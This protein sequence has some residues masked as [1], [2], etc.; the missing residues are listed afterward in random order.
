VSAAT[1]PPAGKLL[2]LEQ[3]Q[4]AYGGIR[5][6]KGIDLTVEPNETVCLIGANGAGKTTT[7]KA[8]TGLVRAAAGKI[9]AVDMVPCVARFRPLW[10]QLGVNK[11][12]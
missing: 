7:L 11:A 2:A 6:V 8:I 4:V 5:A 1:R 3:L 12:P 9:D 10:N